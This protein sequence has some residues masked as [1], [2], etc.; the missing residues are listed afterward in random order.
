MSTSGVG[1]ERLEQRLGVRTLQR[2]EA[3][4]AGDVLQADVDRRPS[5]RRCAPRRGRCSG[6]DHDHELVLEPIDGAVVH[7]G[8]LGREDRGVLHAARLQRADVVAGDPVDEGVAV[9]AGDLEL[10]HVG[11]VEDP[12]AGAN[13]VVL[14]EDA[15]GILH[16]HLPAGER[17]QLGAQLPGGRRRARCGWRDGVVVIEFPKD[18]IVSEAKEAMPGH[19]S[20]RCA[21]GDIRSPTPI[22]VAISAFCTCS[23]FSAWFQTRDWGPSITSSATSSPDGPG[24]S[25]G[26]SPPGRP[27]S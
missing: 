3:H 16:R 7:E 2:E 8:A 21:Q 20:L 1:G 5:A 24:G 6:V 26:R 13:G 27:A 17:H 25:A 9:G 18:V 11:D 10:A 19:G 15:G 12:G 22:S 23:R 14:G 4:L